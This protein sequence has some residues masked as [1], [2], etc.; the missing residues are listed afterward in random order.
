[1]K[2]A[3]EKKL[4]AIK[5]KQ[6]RTQKK[7]LYIGLLTIG[8]FGIFMY[9][10]FRITKKQKQIIEEQ[11]FIVEQQKELVDI[12]QKEILDSIHYAK[13][14]QKAMFPNKNYIN[15]ILLKHKD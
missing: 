5:L 12:K 2:V 14:I 6:E 7:Y 11:K 4:S 13:R 10:R 15:R 3:E 9:N 1:M 8:L